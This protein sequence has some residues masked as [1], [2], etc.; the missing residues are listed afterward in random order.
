MS[1]F[2]QEMHTKTG[3]IHEITNGG[4]QLSL[5]SE[6]L[7][8]LLDMQGVMNKSPLCGSTVHFD[9]SFIKRFLPAVHGRLHY[10]NVDVSSFKELVMRWCPEEQQWVK[11]DQHRALPDIYES[12]K[13]LRYYRS[14]F[15][16]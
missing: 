4:A 15:G 12:I 10:R 3:L 11:K 16:L 7:C 8:S 1:P 2:V 5:I 14:I 6:D 13:E 9:R